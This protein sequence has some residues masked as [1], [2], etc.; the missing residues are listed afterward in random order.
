MAQITAALVKE[1]REATSLGM[2]DCK[3]ALDATDGD[4]EA[5]Q[6]LLREKFKTKLEAR[7]ARSTTEGLVRIQIADDA[8]SGAMVEIQC[9]TDFCSRND[10]FRAMADRQIAMAFV[11]PTGPIEATAE[12]TADVQA[13]FAKIGENMSYARGIKLEAAQIGSYLH[14]NEKVGVLVALDGEVDEEVVQGLCQHI[15]FS[16]P[17]AILPEDVDPELVAKEKEFALKEAIDSGKPAEI[18]EKMVAGKMRKFL[19][20]NALM[21]QNYVKDEKQTIKGM[22]GGKVVTAF[23]RYAVGE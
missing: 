15:A 4:M 17:L 22:L 7:S 11:A 5:A 6:A 10:E 18:A 21:E 3:K 13:A 14:H 2:M 20:Q 23:A 16:N 19:S 9:E 1:L 12:M 8:K